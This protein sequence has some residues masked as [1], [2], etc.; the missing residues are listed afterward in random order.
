MKR[1]MWALAAMTVFAG[2]ATAQ[3]PAKAPAAKTPSS[4]TG[5]DAGTNAGVMVLRTPGQA[6]RKVKIVK[7]TKLEDGRTVTEVKDVATG[8][9]LYVQDKPAVQ[10]KPEPKAVT[11]LADDLAKKPTT[12]AESMKP[13]LPAM[14]V[15]L[16]AIEMPSISLP[17]PTTLKADVAKMPTTVAETIKSP[18]LPKAK[19]IDPAALPL[20]KSTAATAAKSTMPTKAEPAAPKS[21]VA[22]TDPKPTP[23]TPS[24]VPTVT[25][26]AKAKETLVP[27]KPDVVVPAAVPAM[28]ANLPLPMPS[29][30]VG[31]AGESLN[32]QLPVGVIPVEF[33]MKD[34]TSADVAS[35]RTAMR[36]TERQ[37]AATALAD[38]RYGSQAEIKAVLAASAKGDPAAV[39]RAHCITCL[40]KL[41]YCEPDH[42]AYLRQCTMDGDN[43][44]RSAAANALVKLM[45]KK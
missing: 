2:G 23:A 41:G 31:R 13:S 45:P 9:T 36:P 38:G 15:E 28:P 26:T 24:K 12:L 4:A 30:A 25:R 11:T 18:D 44:V 6:D 39:V 16:P 40:S 35:L 14:P 37:N 5:K 21:T 8:E 10:P 27:A 17:A 32:V 42:V 33:R 1:R 43:D 3:V 20:P 19:P 22:K 29:G 34:E 7:A